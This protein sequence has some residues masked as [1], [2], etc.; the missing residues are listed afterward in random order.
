[1]EGSRAGL[2]WALCSP[3]A[4]LQAPDQPSRRCES[5]PRPATPAQERCEQGDLGSLDPHALPAL[6]FPPPAPHLRGGE[7]QPPSPHLSKLNTNAF[8]SSAGKMSGAH[9][10]STA[11]F[12]CT[13]GPQNE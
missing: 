13:V 10:E 3:L 4:R 2:P 8:H 7:L 5:R 6:L 12:L 1:M 11:H 9:S